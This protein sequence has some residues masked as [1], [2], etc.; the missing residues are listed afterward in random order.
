LGDSPSFSYS[1]ILSRTRGVVMAAFME[2]NGFPCL[3]VRHLR[4][5]N[6]KQ[7]KKS[8][9]IDFSISEWIAKANLFCCKRGSDPSYGYLIVGYDSFIG[10]GGL[11]IVFADGN[12]MIFD[13]VAIEWATKITPAAREEQG[14]YLVKIVD[15][16]YALSETLVGKRYNLPTGY[17]EPESPEP[18][19]TFDYLTETIKTD[20]SEV[21]YSWD[22]LFQ[23]VWKIS[24]GT[25]LDTAEFT[26]PEYTPQDLDWR[27]V[28]RRDAVE[29]LFQWTQS[30]A[31]R[32]DDGS[33]KLVRVEDEGNAERDNIFSYFDS[34]FLHKDR[35]KRFKEPGS[36]TPT[37]LILYF[38]LLT[39]SDSPTEQYEKIEKTPASFTPSKHELS[40]RLP[41]F[42]QDSES[43]D[44][45]QDIETIAT[46]FLEF[47]QKHFNLFPPQ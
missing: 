29:M 4:M 19:G 26:F 46:E 31:E 13:D 7:Q 28:T 24:N 8:L 2:L 33:F 10:T 35:F 18:Y 14:Y 34:F 36:E 27:Y 1:I 6:A 21:P 47:T 40:I 25:P 9:K 17:T 20:P 41:A 15:G 30:S 5:E 43:V 23:E 11:R 45:A 44:P 39:E 12:E 16:R 22:D 37:K 32:K 42:F 3:S 38:N